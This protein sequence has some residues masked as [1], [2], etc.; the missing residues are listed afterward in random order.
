[1]TDLVVMAVPQDLVKPSA[2]WIGSEVRQA[3]ADR[4][5][6]TLALAGGR[7]PE[8]VYRVLASDSTIDWD[9]VD[10][11][12][13][14]ERAV[15]PEDP[16]SNYGMIRRALISRVSIPPAR[17]HR[18]KAES[19]DRDAAAWA[20]ERTL[21]SSLDVL[22]LGIG[23]DG[24]TASLFPGSTALDEQHRLVVPVVGPKPPPNR[25]TLTPPVIEAARSVAVIATGADKAAVVA[26]A[27]EGP[28]MPWEIPAQLARR[29]RWFLDQAAAE[30]LTE[31][32]VPT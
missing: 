25:L 4:G 24:H 7:T 13:T 1:M 9:K 10:L 32:R 19:P 11:Y 8:P 17:V 14:D 5:S 31:R 27:I 21:P 29:G 2:A 16:E 28:W 20:Y 26:R 22:V 23:Q 12:F 18:M 15:P 30:R 6:C 3:V